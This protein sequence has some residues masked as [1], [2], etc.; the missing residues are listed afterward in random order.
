[1]SDTCELSVGYVSGLYTFYDTNS[2]IIIIII[3]T[4]IVYTILETCLYTGFITTLF[5]GN[6]IILFYYFV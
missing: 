6:Y 2:F 5:N 1:M 3:I 4:I